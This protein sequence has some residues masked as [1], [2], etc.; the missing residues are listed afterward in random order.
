M[1]QEF[2]VREDGKN[3]TVR[4][5]GTSIVR[6]I[7]KRIGK[8]DVLTIPVRSVHG[9]FHDRKT[10]GTDVVRVQV[11]SVGHEWKVKDADGFVAALN[12]AVASV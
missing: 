2:T 4:I 7:S 3:G 11:G 8:D 1:S 9:V 12:G 6:V 10:L 5:E